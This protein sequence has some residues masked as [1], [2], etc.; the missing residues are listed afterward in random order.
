MNT[1]VS[2]PPGLRR[3]LP[4]APSLR[5]TL[6]SRPRFFLAIF[7]AAWVSFLIHFNPAASA[8]ERFMALSLALVEGRTVQLDAYREMTRDLARRDDH[9][10]LDTNPGLS[11]LALPA[12]ALVHAVLGPPAGGVTSTASFRYFA[13]HFAGLA[14]TT[15][16]AG[17]LT[18]VLI[19]AVLLQ[20]TGKAWKA[21]LGALLYGFGSIAFFFSTRLQQNVVIA[22]FATVTWVLLRE[23]PGLSPRRRMAAL[24]FLLGLGLFVDLSI[25]PLGLAVLLAL[26]R[27]RLLARS[28]LPLAL[29][30]VVPLACLAVYQQMAFAHPL[31]PAQAYIPRAG[32]VLESGLLGLTFPSPARLLPQ[33]VSL[34]CGLLVFMPWTVLA[35]LPDRSRNRDRP[36]LSRETTFLGAAVVLYLLWVAILPSFR[37]CQFGPRYLLPVVPFL[38]VLAVLKLG[39]WPRLGAALMAA[40]FLINLAGAQVGIPTD[41]VARTVAV[42]LLRGPWLPFVEWMQTSL[43]EGP[44]IVTPYG[45]LLLWALA[46]GA[47][48]FLG[49]RESPAAERAP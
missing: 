49:R 10:Y 26:G 11:Y 15:A 25:V 3:A 17:A 33:I 21:L 37:F 29:G 35:L 7:L 27:E 6:L 48:Y 40:G 14:T 31:W 41:N 2:H 20:R 4:I 16:P 42:Y 18:C 23:D 22:C 47:L 43:P 24:G 28:L 44:R 36:F 39:S 32:S 19:A 13:S 30:A 9:W 45:L 5:A 12:V 34:D 38:T 46:L 1:S 8:S